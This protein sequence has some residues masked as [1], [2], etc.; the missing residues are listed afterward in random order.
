MQHKSFMVAVA[1]G[2]GSGKS[3]FVEQVRRKLPE[4]LILVLGQD[5]YYRDLSHLTPPERERRNFDH[6]GAIDKELLV[7]HL[8]TLGAGEAILRPTYDFKS[9][10][11]TGETKIKA[12]P[13]TILDGI[14]AFTFEQ[15]SVFDLKLFI[16]VDEDIRLVRR[17]HR[18]T[19]ERGRSVE[20]V[21][22]QYLETVKPMFI[23]HVQ[24]TRE[25]ADFVVPWNNYNTR[26][27][28]R[29]VN[30]IRGAVIEANEQ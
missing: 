10:T 1:G 6:P 8:R 7:S 26:A 29:V 15:G 18:D 3:T 9:H 23:E 16:D 28:D 21:T 11:R 19:T 30:M 2:S 12:R 13:V 5:H 4:D 17:L 25:N 27:V 24:P 20:S 22:R 14:F